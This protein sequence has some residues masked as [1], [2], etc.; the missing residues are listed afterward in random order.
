MMQS[1]PTMPG[2][3]TA[4]PGALASPTPHDPRRRF[5][6]LLTRR[7]LRRSVVGLTIAVVLAG[8]L[9]PQQDA[10][11]SALNQDRT[12]FGRRALSP[13]VQ[14]QAKAQA[15]AERLAR[16]GR[17][18]HSTLTDGAPS[19]WT[20]L[21]ENVGYGGSIGTIE[22]AYMHSPH[23][24]ENILNAAYTQG[25]VGVATSGDRTY[26]VQEFMSGC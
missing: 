17:L 19:C 26:T 5:A 6:P 13:Q 8:C 10:G 24:R 25:A 4:A 16:D 23:H 22:V 11:L 20:G 7:V 3:L 14:L 21:G 15:W 1:T 2:R 12:S 18:Y 9:S